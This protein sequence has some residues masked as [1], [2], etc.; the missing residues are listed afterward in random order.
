[1]TEWKVPDSRPRASP[2]RIR[3][4]CDQYRS[5]DLRHAAEL[6]PLLER[7]DRD[8]TRISVHDMPLNGNVR[9][10]YRTRAK[11]GELR[12]PPP[13]VPGLDDDLR[14][15]AAQLEAAADQPMRH[16]SVDLPS[17]I[18]YVVFELVDDRRIA[19]VVKVVDQRVVNPDRDAWMKRR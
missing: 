12:T 15:L 18:G 17:G 9:S 6:F 14:A 11:L 8:E 2:E 19:G 10:T 4:F 5:A 13:Q 7:N 1:V 3:A 16:W